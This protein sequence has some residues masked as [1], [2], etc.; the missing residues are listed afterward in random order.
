MS[1]APIVNCRDTQIS[2]VILNLISNAKDAVLPLKEKWI[3]VILQQKENKVVL[4]VVDSG[5]GISLDIREQIFQP[6]FTTKDVGNGTG[7]G[8]SISNEIIKMHYG[9]LFIDHTCP[10]TCFTIELPLA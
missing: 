10:N 4:Q 1:S 7:L 6:F 3:K 2:Q 5:S 9:R 8:L